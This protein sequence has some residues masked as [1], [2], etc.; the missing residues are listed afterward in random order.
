VGHRRW[1]A[2]AL[3]LA[4]S[5]GALLGCGGG[6][7]EEVSADQLV[8]KGDQ[9]CTEERDR[10]EEIQSVPL[11]SASVGAKQAEELLASAEAAQ[12]DLRELEPPEEIRDSYDSYLDARDE[13]SDL[14]ER[15]RAAAEDKDGAAFG[16]AQEAAAAGAGK[17]EKLARAL[18]FKV[19]SQSGAA[20]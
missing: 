1:I 6:G 16:K 14:L 11:T 20:P 3:P 8:A 17:R 7:S 18:G 19:C 4:L 13:V 10:F 5:M 15:G 12:G 2:T 9:I